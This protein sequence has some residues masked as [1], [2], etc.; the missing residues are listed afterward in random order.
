MAVTGTSPRNGHIP[1]TP[2]ELLVPG[3]EVSSLLHPC[4][5]SPD[6]LLG[7]LLPGEARV[8]HGGQ[9]PQ[10]SWDN[11]HKAINTVTLE[12]PAQEMG[13]LGKNQPLKSSALLSSRCV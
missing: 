11:G 4:F 13:G 5:E 9:G 1:V 12:I 7:S 6:S 8:G 3:E 2:L 10:G